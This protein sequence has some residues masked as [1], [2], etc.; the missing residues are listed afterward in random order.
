MIAQEPFDQLIKTYPPL[1]DVN[2]K[3][4]EVIRDQLTPSDQ[5]QGIWSVQVSDVAGLVCLTQNDVYAF[6][7]QKMFFLFKFPAVQTFHRAHL[8][9]VQQHG[10]QVALKAQSDPSNSPDDYEENTLK[11]GN[12]SEAQDF[13]QRL[14]LRS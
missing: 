9:S 13:E 2:R 7:T 12:S 10:V 4:Q 3:L 1:G 14:G 5:V 8:R 11:F 6:W